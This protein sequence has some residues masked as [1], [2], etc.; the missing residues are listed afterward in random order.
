MPNKMKKESIR[1]V[2][3]K[4]NK[5]YYWLTVVS[6]IGISAMD[7]LIA[8]IFK[9]SIDMAIS[10]DTNYQKI[11]I[12]ACVTVVL[13]IGLGYFMI[14]MFS[15]YKRR[16]MRSYR[17]EFINRILDKKIVDM[18]QDNIGQYLS[19]LNNDMKGIED[20]YVE[21]R[22]GLIAKASKIVLCGTLMFVL[23][24]QMSLFVVAI[25]WIPMILVR[26]LNE[27]YVHQR[28]M[29]SDMAS[30]FNILIKELI[31]GFSVI[32]SFNI[33]DKIRSTV[34]EKN[35][36]YEL[37]KSGPFKTIQWMDIVMM[38]IV[39]ISMLVTFCWGAM[40]ASH[41]IITIGTV[42][43]VA[44]LMTTVFSS[45]S[46][47]IKY[48]SKYKGSLMLLD[49][50]DHLAAMTQEEE[51]GGKDMLKDA[52]RLEDICFGYE[53]NKL[54]LN[55]ID[56][57]FEKNKSY[58]I[59][60]I[61]GC[62]KST[63]L[64]LINGYFKNYEGEVWFDESNL[65]NLSSMEVGRLVSVIQ[66]EVFMFDDTLRNNLTLY[67]DYDEEQVNK[68]IKNIGMDDFI[69]EHG[70]NYLC[71]ENGQNLSG[72]QKQRISI[73]RALL[74]N[75]PVL[76]LD[77]VTSALDLNMAYSIEKLILSLEDVTKIVITHRLEKEILKQYDEI[78]MMKNGKIV[79]R[80]SFD[81]I[82]DQKQLFYSLYHT[83]E[84]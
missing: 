82:M 76:L 20:D 67:C 29:E 30:N 81:E 55:H 61:S 6:T 42:T 39:L 13:Y 3:F 77:E 47:L 22:V 36:Q 53:E 34:K 7:T 56:V 58:A 28:R 33:E 80:G 52:I 46:P 40:L 75:T 16:A 10:K 66:Q 37:V 50:L 25:M 38:S 1:N 62:G 72:G 70:E 60:G 59:V 15:I 45:I 79:E 64:K 57:T 43:A 73:G 27:R 74:R 78:I 8:W 14:E 12:L 83:Y 31:S 51:D 41:G 4:D 65:R 9:M 18:K 63:L 21:G 48:F 32:K 24:Y 5:I 71:G 54:A 23:S 68:V 11:L 69:E 26:K 2:I 84:K 17:M 19:A 44:Q 49:K 35:E